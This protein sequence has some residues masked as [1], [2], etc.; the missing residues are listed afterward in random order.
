M[1]KEILSRNP[2]YIKYYLVITC[3]YL[4]CNFWWKKAKNVQ[5]FLIFEVRIEKKMFYASYKGVGNKVL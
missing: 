2:V 1:V 4:F 3:N 5:K